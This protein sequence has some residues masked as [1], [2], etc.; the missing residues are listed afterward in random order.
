MQPVEDPVLVLCWAL[1]KELREDP[2]AGLARH[3]ALHGLQD[4]VR[5]MVG[6][7]VSAQ[8]RSRRPRLWRA[9]KAR[10]EPDDETRPN[11]YF[12]STSP[13]LLVRGAGLGVWCC[14]R[15]C[16]VGASTGGRAAW[17]D[18]GSPPLEGTPRRQ[19]PSPTS[20][21]PVSTGGEHR[22]LVREPPR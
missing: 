19:L 14:G 13:F 18:S 17:S 5:T 8:G 20:G 6:D 7:V 21:T 22:T 4:V 11:W 12:S 1:L 15:L 10:T 16:L 9:A 3:H 2:G